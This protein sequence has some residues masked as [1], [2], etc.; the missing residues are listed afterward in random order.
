MDNEFEKENKQGASLENNG[1]IVNGGEDAEKPETAETAAEVMENG[2]TADVQDDEAE[3]IKDD[4]TAPD[5]GEADETSEEKTEEA[6][7]TET[8]DGETAENSESTEV[9]AE[10]GGEQAKKGFVA[11]YK[12]RYYAKEAAKRERQ[13]LSDENIRRIRAERRAEMM[14]REDELNWFQKFLMSEGKYINYENKQAIVLITSLI[15]GIVLFI[16]VIKAGFITKEKFGLGG[17]A[18]K[19]IVYSKD[20]EL[21]C[22]D[23]KNEPVMISDNISS[24][25]AVSYSYVGSGTTVAEDGE[26]VYFIDNAASDGSFS[27]NFYE[28]GGNAEP[29]LI[30]DGVIDY[31]ISY[32]GEGCVYVVHDAE[33]NELTL[34]AY[35][36]DGGKTAKIVDGIGSGNSNYALSSDGEKVIYI[37]RDDN[38]TVLNICNIDGTDAEVIDTDVAQY[39]VTEEREFLYY[40]KSVV[41]DS[42]TSSYSVYEYNLKKGTSQLIDENVITVAL[43]SQ[44]NALIYYKLNGNKIKASDIV[45]DDGDD[46]EETNALREQIAEYEFNDIVC[47]AYR[48]EDGEKTLISDCVFTAVPMD[49]EGKFIAYTEPQKLDEISINLSEISS[50]SEV[51]ALYYMEAMQAEC[52]TYIY[53]LNGFTD[54]VVFENP[55]VYSFANAEN[56]KQFACFTNY[57]QNTGEGKLI[58]ASFN[59]DGVSSYGE[60]EDDVVSFQFAGEGSRIAY[61]RGVQDDGSGTLM[62][63][64]SNIADEI[65][66]SAYYYEVADD[67]F[68]RVFYL[69]D[70]DPDTYGGT[71]H[72]YQQAKDEVIDENVYMFAYR[73]NNNALYMKDYDV[74]TGKGDLYYLDNKKSVLVDEDVSS[75]F[76]FYDM[77]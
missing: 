58:L 18:T 65:S 14:A 60:L 34:Y 4:G 57:D 2:D 25:G 52:D 43:P 72:Y 54:Y 10:N 33:T 61:M 75:V 19:A 37:T 20:N 69:E 53:K 45:N 56:N 76:D 68:R 22:Y 67:Y 42:M 70:Y 15:L 12:E 38:G 74:L 28:A 44:E 55:Y 31:E 41:D 21:Y 7:E 64:E 6:G 40:I 49:D 30:S 77:A 29:S 9:T 13:R 47:S 51:S 66:D 35:D 17:D 39:I 59:E 48:Y 71:F 50:V 36:R 32:K 11:R 27:L 3:E 23:L 73:K 16:V 63:V 5:G 62:Y 8:K 24:G 46:S 1:E 26:S